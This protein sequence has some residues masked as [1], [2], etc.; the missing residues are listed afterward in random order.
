M[1]SL[2]TSSLLHI[3]CWFAVRF[4]AL[5]QT[6]VGFSRKSTEATISTVP[7]VVSVNIDSLRRLQ[8]SL[9]QASKSIFKTS[10]QSCQSL[11]P[12]QPR[13]KAAMQP[14]KSSG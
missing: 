11:I 1:G 5:P 8:S 13:T 10:R 4:L 9:L 6:G 3:P 12:V 2:I 14:F 7:N